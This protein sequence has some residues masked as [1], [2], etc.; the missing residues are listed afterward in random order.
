MSADTH[1]T[2]IGIMFNF[3]PQTDLPG[4]R[5]GLP[6]DPPGFRIDQNG[7]VRRMLGGS[8]S[9]PAVDYDPYGNARLTTLLPTDLGYPGNAGS[10][11]HL[12][13]FDPI[14]S[15]W[16]S[17]DPFGEN[18]VAKTFYPYVRWNP[19]SQPDPTGQSAVEQP[20]TSQN[21]LGSTSQMFAANGSDA[22]WEKCHAICVPQTIGR[23]LPD[24]LGSYR[25]CMR[26]CLISQG[27]F[28]Y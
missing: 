21:N 9:A 3:V 6:E 14:G 22:A 19:V 25:K 13:A 28:D 7:S 1:T 4:F 18:T 17:R 16:P 12:R 24:A 10:G 26:A 15:R 5:V 27:V 23:R 20:S 8:P 11:L 2:R